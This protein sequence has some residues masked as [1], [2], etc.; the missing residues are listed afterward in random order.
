MELHKALKQYFH[1]DR[2]RPGQEEVAA[3]ILSG[4]DAMVVMPTGGGKSLCYQLP[5]LMMEGVAVIVSP[6]IA[7]MK[8]QVDS[9]RE[10]KIEATFINSSL[11]GREQ[12]ERIDAV[13]QGR[14]RLVY[15]APER[16]RQARF[17]EALKKVT[18]SFFAVDEAHCVSMWGHDFR[19]DYLRLGGT[20]EALGRPPV[21]AFTA[22]ATPEVRQDI[23][24][25][26]RL[27]DPRECVTGFA[28]PNLEFRVTQVSSTAEKYLRLSELIDGNR[29]GI[30]Y[31]AT[32]KRV[33]EVA[34]RLKSWDIAHIAYHAGLDDAERKR[35][36]ER[37]LQRKSDVAVATNA[38]G[39]GIDRADIRFLAHFEM[40]GSVEAYY[41]EGG[42]AGRDGKPAVCE[43]LFNY[44]DKRVQEF[45]IEGN[46]PSKAVIV[47]V[48][49][50]LR[51]LADSHS[52]VRRSIRD[53]TSEMSYGNNSLQVNASLTILNRMGVI[54]RFDIPGERIRGTRL[55]QPDLQPHALN[56][57]A[58]ALA[59]KDQRDRGKLQ[60]MIQYG[61]AERCRQAWILH[62]FGERDAQPCGCCDR[63]NEAPPKDLR[64]PTNDEAVILQ[65]ALSGVARA[66]WRGGSSSRW[67]ARYGLNR[68]VQ[69][70]V[71]SRSRNVLDARLDTLST[72][73][74]L[75]EEGL[76]YV[77]SL[78]AA[79]ERA[80][81]VQATD[82]Q[83]RM[84]TLTSLGEQVMKGQSTVKLD[85]PERKARRPKKHASPVAE[86]TSSETEVGK[87]LYEALKSKR[88]QLAKARG[89]VPAYTIF[90]NRSLLGLAS[91]K[92]LTVE[93]AMAIP[94]IGKVR[95][96]TV[97]PA[98][99]KIIAQHRVDS[100]TKGG[101]NA[102]V[103]ARRDYAC[104]REM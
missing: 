89:N 86:T 59:E 34:E 64:E 71:G 17:V 99:L 41:Q 79:M 13:R 15:I 62:Y 60:A 69:M 19:P 78:F 1:F 91:M 84:I 80:G 47:D 9:L 70:L 36:Q 55:R 57:D 94:G 44:A 51:R 37:F 16:F 76:P 6:L 101:R 21:A 48:Y 12:R 29:T 66:S 35:A 18:I 23:R 82:D 11:S 61:Y 4:T 98:F 53:L 22:T 28:R 75:K 3:A 50:H 81:L 97:L 20:F 43:L 95:A 65:K 90:S 74:L 46:N 92:P 7:L 33:E 32:R 2:F 83:Y 72:Y 96:R 54:E 104:D 93:E 26:L 14:I 25:L 8:D 77:K 73:G 38:F 100:E 10:Q 88:L 87:E 45:F 103:P 40:P 31:C 58:A 56:L 85:W 39:M 49:T 30:I 63:C 27:H 24:D 102:S 42:R 67:Q 68:I 5:A 52:E